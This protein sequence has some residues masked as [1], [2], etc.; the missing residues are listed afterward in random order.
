MTQR[1]EL[2]NTMADKIL[3]LPSPLVTRVAIDGVDGA[4]KTMFANEL[5][6]VLQALGRPIIRASVDSFHNP[7]AIRYRLGKTSPE[8]FFHDSYNYE[9]LKK[10]LLKP[11]SPN[12]SRHYKTV[13]F[14]HH[15]D[16]PVL[17]TEQLAEPSSILIF[18]GIFLHRPELRNFWDYSIF[19]E[20]GFDLTYA[21]MAQ[22]DK[23]SPDPNAPENHR[24]LA[25]QTLYLS[26]C[27]PKHYASIIVNNEN[28]A[29]PFVVSS[30]N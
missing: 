15:T 27:Q 24:Y 23:S 22:R 8:G 28:F 5:A 29:T 26:E 19:L 25:G 10:I 21:R 9:L 20:V 2:L 1:Q 14:D 4:G 30:K 12:G 3:E 11:L 13:A 18:D 6:D 17:Q 16:S 7:R